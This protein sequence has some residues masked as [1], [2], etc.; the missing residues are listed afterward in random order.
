MKWTE[1]LPEDLQKEVHQ[2]IKQTNSW[3]EAFDKA[4]N[5]GAA[6]LWTALAILKR[7][8]EK[9]R[10]IVKD[11]RNGSEDGLSEDFEKTLRNY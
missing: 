11:V 6:Q 3:N 10:E 5:P 2:I 4:E 8:N 7:R 1:G 9:L